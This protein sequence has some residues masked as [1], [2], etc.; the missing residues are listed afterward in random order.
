M[1]M[2]C[3]RILD[4]NKQLFCSPYPYLIGVGAGAVISG[5][6]QVSD[7]FTG[8]LFGAP[9]GPVALFV[10]HSLSCMGDST[11]AYA[12]RIAIA[13]F[14]ALALD[15]MLL[16]MFGYTI[17]FTHSSLLMLSGLTAAVTTC[18]LAFNEGWI[19]T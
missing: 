11:M 3:G 5:I 18:V 6:T 9:L 10:Y 1:G 15:T 12:A 19:K 16:T 4:N 17:T 2:D 13:F 7:T 8:A 14:T